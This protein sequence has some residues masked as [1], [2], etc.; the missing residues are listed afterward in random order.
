MAYDLIPYYGCHFSFYLLGLMYDTNKY[1]NI[2]LY[3]DCCVYIRRLSLPTVHFDGGDA[4][5]FLLG[6]LIAYD[7]NKQT[8]TL[9]TILHFYLCGSYRPYHISSQSSVA[10]N[11]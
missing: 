5:P 9:L 11:R 10:G 8:P 6:S 7:I 3:I 4:V 2:L 1:S